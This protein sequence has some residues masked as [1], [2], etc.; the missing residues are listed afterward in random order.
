LDIWRRRASCCRSDKGTVRREEEDEWAGVLGVLVLTVDDDDGV[1][2]EGGWFVLLRRLFGVQLFLSG[3][4]D[5]EIMRWRDQ[6]ME[7]SGDTMLLMGLHNNVV[8]G[9]NI[10]EESESESESER[11]WK[12]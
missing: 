3:S 4:R 12:R 5:G 8:N 9:W 11:E 6:E 1:L 7:R 10:Q 2:G